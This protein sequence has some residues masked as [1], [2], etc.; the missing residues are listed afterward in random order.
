MRRHFYAYIRCRYSRISVTVDNCRRTCA[1]NVKRGVCRRVAV[2][3]S[4]YAT[5]PAKRL[6]GVFL[7]DRVAVLA[8]ILAAALQVA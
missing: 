4:T 8:T 6:Y 5:E 1:A 2:Y 7:S 3:K